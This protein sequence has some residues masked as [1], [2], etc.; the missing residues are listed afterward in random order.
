MYDTTTYYSITY[1]YVFTNLLAMHHSAK[2]L[3]RLSTTITMT[4][5]IPY[6]L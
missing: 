1:Y 5:T 4:M 6:I 3:V 2:Y